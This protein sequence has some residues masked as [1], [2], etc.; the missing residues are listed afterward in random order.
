MP[1]KV[2]FVTYTLKYLAEVASFICVCFLFSLSKKNPFES[3]T[4][5]DLSIYFVDDPIT[6]IN[7][8][9]IKQTKAI[10]F[11]NNLR[12]LKRYNKLYSKKEIQKKFNLRHLVSRSFCEEIPKTS[13]CSKA[14]H[15]LIFLILIT[16]RFA[17]LV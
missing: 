1:N 10:N 8:T 17:L 11:K 14:Q 12:L 9:Y 6:P 3:H 7:A 16:K 2:I 4:I 5:G 13:R 15:F